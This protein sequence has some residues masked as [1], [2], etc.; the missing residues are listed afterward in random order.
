MILNSSRILFRKQQGFTLIEIMVVVVII[1]V[2][3]GMTVISI[4]PSSPERVLRTEAKR[5]NQ[6]IK[7]A[8]DESQIQA[9][10][11]GLQITEEGYQLFSLQNRHWTPIA[12]DKVFENHKW[13][14]DLTTELVLDGFSSFSDNPDESINKGLTHRLERAQKREAEKDD[15]GDKLYHSDDNKNA[16]SQS[17][18]SKKA[19][20][21]QVFILSS[22][23][24]TP[25]SLILEFDHKG[26]E[27]PLYLTLS[28]DYSGTLKMSEILTQRPANYP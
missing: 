22:G 21:P 26:M 24:I 12:N 18:K 17:K 3:A 1:A 15:I 9:T 6:V 4:R 7:M 23:E 11:L 13:P 25:F 16:D 2:F 19:V 14:Q 28:G 27:R 5:L 8:L 10:Q 20:T